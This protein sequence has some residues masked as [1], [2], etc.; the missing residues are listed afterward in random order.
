MKS[1]LTA[2]LLSTLT[3]F[4]QDTPFTPQPIVPGGIILPLYAPTSPLLKR[5]RLQ[6]P[7]N[8]GAELSAPA[9]LFFDEF[10][11]K[12]SAADD[13]LANVSARPDFV[14]IIY[15]GPTPFTKAP[16]TPIPANVPIASSPAPAPATA[17]THCGRPIISRRC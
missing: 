5:E 12:N 2:L 7:E 6:E 14:G 17:S 13:P 4:A 11:K 1:I 10:E 8:A 9:A 16:E 3:S 15:P